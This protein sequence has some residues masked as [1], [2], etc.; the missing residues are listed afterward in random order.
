VAKQQD[1]WEMLQALDRPERVDIHAQV[2][3]RDDLATNAPWAV[4]FET[5]V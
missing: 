2:Y 3:V 4:G 1:D 5:I